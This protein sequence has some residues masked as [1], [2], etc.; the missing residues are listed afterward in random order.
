MRK[1]AADLHVHTCLSPCGDLR[2][3]PQNIV[4]QA[5]V[6]DL[7]IIAVCDH[8]SCENAAA[9][10]QAADRQDLRVL[11]GMEVTSREEVHVV[12]I[13][14]ALE[15]ALALQDIIYEH[16]PGENDENA[17]GQQIVVNQFSEVLGFNN[18]LLIGATDLA[19]G[20]VVEHIHRCGGL[21]IASHIDREGFGII[22]QLGYIPETLELDA[23]ELSTRITPE[24]ARERFQASSRFVFV[25]SSDAHV[26]EQIGSGRTHFILRD[27]VLSE[28]G[29]AFRKEGGRMVTC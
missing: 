27:P 7:D 15:N 9:V 2:M 23:L 24:Q 6:R 17:F 13:F 10:I 4:E 20:R 19:L 21:A 3:S 5:R 18:R 16:L 25:Y 22:G 1:Y 28:I 11:P 12:G 26:P 8:N 29:L 14:D